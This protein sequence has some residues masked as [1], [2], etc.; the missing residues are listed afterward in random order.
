MQIYEELKKDPRIWALFTRQ[1]EYNPIKLDRY[2]RFSYKY[3]EDKNISYPFISDYLIK[4]RNFHVEYPENKKFAVVL[5]HDVDDINISNQ[6]IIRSMVPLP[7]NRD[8]SGFKPLIIEKLK[9]NKT[10]YINFKQIIQLEKKYDAK[11][12]FYF[13]ANEKDIFGNKYKLEDVEEEIVYILDNECEVG[14]HV[15]YY[16][17]DK[18]DKI[19]REKE[20]LEKITGMRINGVR[21]HLLRFN[22]PQ[23]WE[24][25]SKAG[26]IYDAS[27]GYH[28]MVG[29]RNGTCHPFQPFNLITN[30]KIEITEIPV[31]V[32]DI[33][34]FSYMKLNAAK[35]WDYIKNLIDNVEMLGG[36]FALLWHNWTFSFPVSYAGLFGKEWTKLYEKILIYCSEK[37]SWIANGTEI[38]E[39]YKRNGFLKSF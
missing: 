10:A 16:A 8:L 11:S 21:N 14:L 2:G 28:D 1:E 3:S 32:I 17:F 9:G 39:H 6:H 19:I 20:R 35:S 38:Y 37:N 13:L 26:F 25:L 7:I 31:C 22:I 4:K 24:I 34:L 33:T 23:S 30:K 36:V 18:L 15:S 5:T 27:L 12:S 29:F